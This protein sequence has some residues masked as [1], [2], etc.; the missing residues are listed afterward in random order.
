MYLRVRVA[1]WLVLLV[2]A[3][4]AC[5]VMGRRSQRKI[6]I[7]V[8]ALLV[9]LIAP[10]LGNLIITVSTDRL[11]S[12]I[13][14]YIY[15]I[16]LDFT[17]MAALRFTAS[18]CNIEYKG[19]I[20]RRI[21]WAVV[22]ADILQFCAN[23]FFTNAFYLE[24]IFV[25]GSVYWAL[26]PLLGQTIH[27]FV[28]YGIFFI[29]VGI[30]GYKT[31]TVPRIYVERYAIIFAAMIFCGVLET[32]FIFSRTPIDRSM[33]AF[34]LFGLLVYFFAI[35][36]RPVRLL[37]SMLADVVTDMKEAVFFFEKDGK[38][39]YVNSLGRSILGLSKEEEDLSSVLPALIGLVNDSDLMLQEQWTC[40]RVLEEKSGK[41]YMRLDFNTLKDHGG[42]RVGAYLK[43]RDTTKDE[44]LLHEQKHRA[45]HDR[46]TG[47]YNKEHLYEKARELIDDNPDTKFSVIGTDISNFK[48]VNDVF[49]KDF[50]DRM[51]K[52]V[53]Q[54][55]A[56]SALENTVYGRISGDRFGAILPTDYID[57]DRLES[58]LQNAIY[59]DEETG[60]DYNVIV[61]AGLYEIADTSLP[62]SVMFDRAFLSVA[63]IKNDYQQHVA[64]YDEKMR[65]DMLWRQTISSQLEEAIEQKQIQ[66]YLQPMV[67]ENGKTEGAEVLVRWIHPEEGF[68]SPARFIPIFE[69]NGMIARLDVY[70]WEC[71]CQLLK[72]WEGRGI[73]K[74]VSV[75]IS[76][77]DFY[78]I[79]VHKTIRNITEKYQI[80]PE[81]L[82]LEITE[83]V[84]MSDM[85]NR[86]AIIDG[87]RKDGFLVE[88]DDFGS[89]YSSLNML[90][91]I[92]VDMLK[93]DM[94]FLY[95]TKN[96]EK[97]HT[98]LKT[99]IDLSSE[100]GIPSVTE[101]VETAE[102]L[103]MLVN[104]GCRMFQGYYFARPMPV[105]E[106]EKAYLAA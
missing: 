37:D 79:D 99:I 95:K 34:G 63:A 49:S 74:F 23:P 6:S 56:V 61:H 60:V 26:V 51:L 5:V 101:G 88:M 47:L 100:L 91:D 14:S 83:T 9:T 104:M 68:L 10:I 66:P 70:M 65:E 54:L 96:Q 3:L 21:L 33:I 89:G 16:G 92:P 84:M 30:F 73:D 27:R 43:I 62:V 94:M 48:L 103:N 2:V 106:F 85:E 77:K 13:G 90:K 12:A 39:I 52:R 93:I 105:S 71:A 19:T 102:Q 11:L 1:I 59:H 50:G 46:L 45:N 7:D 41:R 81:K 64:C 55:V 38:C 32:F 98:I 86:L 35:R 18:Y 58:V 69:E 15:F 25:D 22:I 31:F 20:L 28:V 24:P 78:F 36:Y 40:D 67:D 87:L 80:N 17:V 75:N 8:R 97:A 82:R 76:P 44:E 29:T 42:K 72:D 57:I 4:L 53:A